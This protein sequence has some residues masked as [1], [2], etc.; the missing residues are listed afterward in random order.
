VEGLF[1]TPHE[2]EAIELFRVIEPSQIAVQ[3]NLSDVV[4]CDSF[5]MSVEF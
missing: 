1:K 4:F 2:A 5:L 3:N